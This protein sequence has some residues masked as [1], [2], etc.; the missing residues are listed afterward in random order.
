M[1]GQLSGHIVAQSPPVLTLD[2]QGVG[3][4]VWAPLSTCAQLMSVAGPVILHIQY[5]VRDETPYLF[6][7]LTP[8]E[9]HLFQL[10]IKVSG[11]GPKTALTML[12]QMPPSELIAACTEK[13]INRLLQV[14]G[15]GKKTA[16]RLLVDIDVKKLALLEV[17]HS[18]PGL[19][20]RHEAQEAL[21]RLGYPDR[22]IDAWLKKVPEHMVDLESVLKHV[23]KHI[24]EKMT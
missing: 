12:S 4:E 6:G 2:V 22:D 11:V 18:L 14:P 3:Y 21:K 24:A 9:K 8:V 19:A 10:L 23:F 20:V 13:A 17:P 7:F 1:I 15:I 5:V 16:E